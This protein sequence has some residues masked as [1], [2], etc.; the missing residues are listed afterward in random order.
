MELY[1]A[2]IKKGV[3]NV[4]ACSFVPIAISK[5]HVLNLK[6][7]FVPIPMS[8]CRSRKLAMAFICLKTSLAMSKEYNS[9]FYFFSAQEINIRIG[10]KTLPVY[11]WQIKALPN[12]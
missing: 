11:A 3:F 9:S 12:R 2:H 4:L 6:C 5:S 10:Q 8:T 1:R 7:S